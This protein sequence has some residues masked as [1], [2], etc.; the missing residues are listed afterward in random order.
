MMGEH[1]LK[2]IVLCCI[3]DSSDKRPCAEELIELLEL[4]RSKIQQKQIIAKGKLPT[5]EVVVLGET[6]VGKSSLIS[7]YFNNTFNDEIIATVGVD[8]N[9][10]TISLLDREFTL[11]V[12]DTAG[13]ERFHSIAP[14]LIRTSQGIALVYDVTNRATLY[15][16][17]PKMC[18]FIEQCRPDNPPSL[19]L[20]G[21]KADLTESEQG[22]RAITINEGAAFAHKL[23][24]RSIETSAFSGQNVENMFRMIVNEIDR[25]LD[26]S[27]IDVYISS[28]EKVD[29]SAA[30]SPSTTANT[31]KSTSRCGCILGLTV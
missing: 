19:I 20:V 18:Q 28:Q 16:G 15:E 23:G 11:K 30:A 5:I 14:S 9:M 31:A 2:N 12:V 6:C 17:V 29:I 24:I 8:Y 3:E 10:S 13:Q 4:E 25:N 26:L 27:D 7:R 1:M 21:N 22:N